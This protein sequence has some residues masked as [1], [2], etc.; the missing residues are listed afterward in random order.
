M[1]PKLQPAVTLKRQL[2]AVPHLMSAWPVAEHGKA[3]LERVKLTRNG[4]TWEIECDY[5][6]CRFHLIPNVELPNLMG[7]KLN[8]TFV[9]VDEWQA[10]SQPN[11]YCAG[12]PTGIGGVE[13]A[14][15]EGQVAGL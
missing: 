2:A 15:I 13:L 6:A 1:P 12:E 4:K 9:A 3:K 14:I 5:F 11:V 8:D 7:C 10:T